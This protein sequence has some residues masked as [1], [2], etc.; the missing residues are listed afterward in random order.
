MICRIGEDL[1]DCRALHIVFQLFERQVEGPVI[2]QL[3][4]SQLACSF[5]QPEKSKH[6]AHLSHSAQSS[7]QEV[8]K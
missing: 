1:Q 5:V 8:T 3:V 7:H 6:P 4:E 2:P